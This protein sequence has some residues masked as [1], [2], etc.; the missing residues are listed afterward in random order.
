MQTKS[1]HFCNLAVRSGGLT[2]S[3]LFHAIHH[4]ITNPQK[5]YVHFI[6]QIAGDI[7]ISEGELVRK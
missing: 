7:L 1:P 3:T 5:R 6:T 2:H 4:Q